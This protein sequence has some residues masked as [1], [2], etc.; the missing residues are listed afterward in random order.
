MGDTLILE[1]APVYE[2]LPADL[3][4]MAEV[5]SAAVKDSLFWID[6]DN[7]SLGKQKE[8]AFKFKVTEDGPYYDR[9][10]YGRTSTTFNSNDNCRLRQWVEEIF[11]FGDLPVGFE[12]DTD[13]LAGQPVKIV[14]G[15]N[16]YTDK[17][18]DF[19][20]TNYVLS[21]L[22]AEAYEDF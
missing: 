10:V 14:V 15:I 2:L 5:V 16:E 7:H 17:K 12:F 8:V 3:V 9:F 18:G 1:E 22:R 20:Q 4:V 21:L 19:K 13:S 11:A 6:K